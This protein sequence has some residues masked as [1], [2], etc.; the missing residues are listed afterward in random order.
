MWSVVV[1]DL[2]CI[3]WIMREV[4]ELRELMVEVCSSQPK[5]VLPA[6]WSGII[7]IQ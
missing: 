7:L 6:V 3:S 1:K 4:R 2:V 5:H